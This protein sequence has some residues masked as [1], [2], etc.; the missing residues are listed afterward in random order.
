MANEKWSQFPTQ[1]SI[2]P[3]DILVGLHG[4]VN[5]QF[6]AQQFI[7]YINPCAVATT[8]ALTATYNNGSS[9]VGATLTNSGT[10]AA[11]VIDGV[12]LSTNQR[13]LVKN[14]SSTFQNGIYSVTT[15]GSGSTNW[16]L[17]RA[18][19]Y[20]QIAQIHVGDI[21]PVL[22]GTVN[23][24]LFFTQTATVTVIGT[25]PITFSN[26]T[27]NAS[28]KTASDNTLPVLAS[29]SGTIASGHFA[30]FSDTTGTISD[31][32]FLPLTDAN[33]LILSS[34]GTSTA[35]GA[36]TITEASTFGTIDSS[37][38]MGIVSGSISGAVSSDS[39]NFAVIACN[40]ASIVSGVNS[41]VLATN[42][43]SQIN[44]SLNSFI[45]AASNSNITAEGQDTAIIA[46]DSCTSVAAVMSGFFG[47]SSGSM[48]SAG[49]GVILG[50]AS[51][52]LTNSASGFILGGNSNAVT[53]GAQQGII[54][55]TSCSIA[56]MA[57]NSIAMGNEVTIS[58]SDTIAWNATGSFTT[59]QTGAFL[60][61]PSSGF[62]V[63]VTT[64]NATI[65][66]S[67]N[68]ILGTNGQ[69]SSGS[70]Q[71][72]SVNIYDNAPYLNF[73]VKTAGGVNNNMRFSEVQ[74][75]N[76]I[77]TTTYTVLA[78]DL[79]KILIFTNSSG[80]TVTLPQQSTTTLAP[81]F[82]FNYRNTGIG[83]VT[84]TTQ[85]SDTITGPLIANSGANGT[86]QI[87]TAG[88]PNV[89]NNIGGT[90]TNVKQL[91]AFEPVIVNGT[92]AQYFIDAN[93]PEGGTL[94]AIKGWLSSAT[95][96]A[97]L[98]LNNGATTA[99]QTLALS[100]TPATA[101]VTTNNTFPGGTNISYSI[102][103][104]ATSPANLHVIAVYT[105]AISS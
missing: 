55:G 5:V 58:G 17:T 94:T 68:N 69:I 26:F 98:S 29:V 70:L 2:Q 60:L 102:G 85:G 45:A 48:S 30:T 10:Q 47:T 93:T 104:V 39:S 42:T 12:S 34:D 40:N 44:N 105:V 37:S 24:H 22:L 77:S 4:G 59:S 74:I 21:I 56:S 83:V 87:I 63:G 51:N 66:T 95:G 31:E 64:A 32:G 1:G 82:K 57:N 28:T 92:G 49:N 23:A 8:A 75:Q 81:S 73:N 67:G 103:S 13:V 97:T 90:S 9:G 91:F 14:Q 18:A 36:E 33:N 35:Q 62:G 52:S 54:N 41:V 84:F 20:N 86:I 53:T 72:S 43:F 76:V 6:T 96:T 78:T 16:V 89:W 25:S 11:L 79:N 65:H 100:T 15:V 46:S 50:G 71:N 19:D 101:S 80:C 61:N 3:G 99:I 27:N 7:V 38:T 88:T